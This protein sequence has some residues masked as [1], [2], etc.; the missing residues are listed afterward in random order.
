MKRISLVLFVVFLAATVQAQQKVY[1]SISASCD[2]KPAT[3]NVP[4]GKIASGFTLQTLVSGNN[5]YN[6]AAIRDKGFVIKSANGKVL[7]RYTVDANGRVQES[8]GK[9]ATLRLSPGSYTFWVDGGR[10]AQLILNY[11]I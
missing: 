6:G 1:S 8:G 3:L 11:R 10:G 5:C 2:A 7:F 4:S 9:L